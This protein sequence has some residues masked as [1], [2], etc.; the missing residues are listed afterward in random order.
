MIQRIAPFLLL[1][2]GLACAQ[3]TSN[4]VTVTASRNT[5]LP[6]DQIVFRVTV[7]TPLDATR[8]DAV[9]ALQGSGITLAN[10][11]GVTTVQIYDSRGQQTQTRLQWLFSLPVAVSNMK[12]TIGLLTAVQ[13]SNAQKNNGLAILFGIAGTQVSP[14]ALQSQICSQADLLADARAQAQKMASA[15]GATLGAVLAMSGSTSATMDSTGGLFSSP[16]Y[17]PSCF[18]TVKFALGGF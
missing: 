10:F 12:S 4:S 13:K 3:L 14:Q 15:A 2:A 9:S 1:S 18:L 6:P 5:N 11:S 16:Y 8:D 17:T 7:D